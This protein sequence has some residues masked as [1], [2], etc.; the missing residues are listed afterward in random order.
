MAIRELLRYG[1]PK[2]L[3]KSEIIDFPLDNEIKDLI[4]DLK[5]TM[6]HHNGAGITAPQIGVFK[7]IIYFGFEE[8]PRYPEANEISETVLINP[9]WQPL[10]EKKKME[11]KGVY[12]SQE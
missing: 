1:D 3:S 12:P 10:S 11:L 6:V 4:K 9:T 2:L 8:N 5:D 7:R